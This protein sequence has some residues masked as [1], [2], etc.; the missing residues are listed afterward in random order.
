M[1]LVLI[2]KNYEMASG[3]ISQLKR[4]E[5]TYHQV[6]SA[7]SRNQGKLLSD[8]KSSQTKTCLTETNSWLTGHLHYRGQCLQWV[9]TSRWRKPLLWLRALLYQALFGLQSSPVITCDCLYDEK[10]WWLWRWGWDFWW[11]CSMKTLP[12]W[13]SFFIFIIQCSC[14]S[15]SKNGGALFS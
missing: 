2:T 9:K 12:T 6:Q 7:Q 5:E 15:C 10:N 8:W 1:N 4:W 14:Q 3:D 11:R 13:G